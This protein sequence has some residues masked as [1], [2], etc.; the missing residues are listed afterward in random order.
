MTQSDEKTTRQESDASVIAT[1]AAKAVYWVI[2]AVALLFT[3]YRVVFPYSAMKLYDDLGNVPRAYEC[4]RQTANGARGEKKVNARISCVNYCITL[5][6]EN[7]DEYAAELERNTYEF[8][9]DGDCVKRIELIDEYN[10]KNAGAAIKPN[11]YSYYA[12]LHAENAR[13]RLYQ[14]KTDL[15][16]GGEYVNADELISGELPLKDG[17]V[18]L[19]QISAM[20]ESLTADGKTEITFLSVNKLTEYAAKY[21]EEVLSVAEDKPTLEQTYLLKAYEKLIARLSAGGFTDEQTIK[22]LKTVYYNGTEY[23]ISD[24]YYGVFLK[25]YGN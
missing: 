20:L 16:S 21:A 10:V 24:L 2:I 17:A 19:G 12:Y 23:D 15:L 25:N 11:L 18:V 1:T 5:F 14:G 9:T 4:A 13:A 8:L 22:G 7:P 3:L 6:G